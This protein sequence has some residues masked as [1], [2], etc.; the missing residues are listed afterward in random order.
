[1][2]FNVVVVVLAADLDCVGGRVDARVVALVHVALDVVALAL[3]LAGVV[4]VGLGVHALLD[5]ALDVL[6]FVWLEVS[7][8][9]LVILLLLHGG[10]PFELPELVH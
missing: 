9:L 3:I 7:V 6:V 4:L 8:L 10:P 2:P 5:V 1:V